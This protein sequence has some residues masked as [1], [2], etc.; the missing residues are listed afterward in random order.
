MAHLQL[1][2]PTL[3]TLV[4]HLLVKLPFSPTRNCCHS[5]AEL[6]TTL[7]DSMGGSTPGFRVHHQLPELT[8]THVH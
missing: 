3:K 1:P 8:Q 5:F 6:L 7:C 4:L 2:S